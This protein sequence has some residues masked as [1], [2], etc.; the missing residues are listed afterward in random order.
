MAIWVRLGGLIGVGY[1]KEE[2]DAH[3][4]LFVS[5]YFCD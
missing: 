3:R 5:L 1:T 2:F 4:D